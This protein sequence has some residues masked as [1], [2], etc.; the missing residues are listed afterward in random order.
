MAPLDSTA[1]MADVLVLYASTHGHT[2]KVAARIADGLRA[3]GVDEVDVRD[4]AAD[5]GTLDPGAYDAVIAG[6]SLHAGHHQRSLSTGSS[7]IAPL[8]L[9]VP[10]LSSPSP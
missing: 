9:I 4:G 10:R 7:L 8:L 6:G 2:A 1:N 3:V 5:A